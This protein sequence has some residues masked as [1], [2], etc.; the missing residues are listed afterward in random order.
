MMSLS[1]CQSCHDQSL[2]PKLVAWNPDS[3]RAAA[4]Q[5]LL[6]NQ[7]V[8][9]MHHNKERALVFKFHSFAIVPNIAASCPPSEP[10]NI[11]TPE[12]YEVIRNARLS[13]S[14]QHRESLSDRR[15]SALNTR[16]CKARAPC[17]RQPLNNHSQSSSFVHICAVHGITPTFTFSSIGLLFGCELDL[18]S[19]ILKT[20]RGY[21]SK[22]EAKRAVC[23]LGVESLQ[24]KWQRARHDDDRNVFG[25]GCD[26]KREWQDAAHRRKRRR[27]ERELDRHAARIPPGARKAAA[28]LRAP[29]TWSRCI[30]LFVDIAFSTVVLRDVLG[31]S[32]ISANDRT[33]DADHSGQRGLVNTLRRRV[34]PLHEEAG[35]QA[36]HS[37][38]RRPCAARSAS[39]AVKRHYSYEAD[40]ARPHGS[41]DSAGSI[42]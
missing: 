25:S 31:A 28:S 20:P 42:R 34:V 22:K 2:A 27:R 17:Q 41:E 5:H 8:E 37:E 32:A 39:D 9:R 7:R 35:R 11:F 10:L 15:N 18:G 12:E 1:V 6:C 29:H 21:R 40:R 36:S 38:T 19:T 23:L 13:Y 26:R 33:I 14:G 16:K 3:C 24:K 30:L 4:Q